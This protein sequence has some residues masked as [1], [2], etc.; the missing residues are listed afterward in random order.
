MRD[1]QSLAAWAA[2]SEVEPVQI[3]G[4]VT[5]RSARAEISGPEHELV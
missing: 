3:T 5:Y 1:V 2:E 4:P